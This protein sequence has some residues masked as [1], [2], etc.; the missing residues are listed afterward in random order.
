MAAGLSPAP[1]PGEYDADGGE[2]AIGMAAGP[3]VVR[4]YISE[5]RLRARAIRALSRQETR[6]MPRQFSRHGTE[7][8]KIFQA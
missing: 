7:G 3:K 4:A 1:L 6:V 5:E 2:G 8:W